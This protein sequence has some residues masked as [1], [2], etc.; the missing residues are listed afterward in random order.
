MTQRGEESHRPLAPRGS[1]TC[2]MA[3]LCRAQLRA[4]VCSVEDQHGAGKSPGWA[5]C[6]TPGFNPLGSALPSSCPAPWWGSFSPS[7]CVFPQ[8]LLQST[9]PHPQL[10]TLSLPRR[11]AAAVGAQHRV[12]AGSP[13]HLAH[14]PS[15]NSLSHCPCADARYPPPALPVPGVPGRGWC[16]GHDTAGVSDGRVQVAGSQWGHGAR[17][18]SLGAV[19]AT[20]M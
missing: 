8:G 15:C 7:G 2:S 11:G 12:V 10:C 20:A 16:G 5:G 6:S 1:R 14:G 3:C 17:G 19:G 9:P 18:A 4:R 13:P